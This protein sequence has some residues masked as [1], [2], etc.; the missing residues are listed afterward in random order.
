MSD[1]LVI[2]VL[3]P[4]V[5]A[6]FGVTV[7]AI[8]GRLF[9]LIAQMTTGLTLVA[10]LVLFVALDRAQSGV[11]FASQHPW[12]GENLQFTLGLDGVSAVGFVLAALVGFAGTLLGRDVQ[13][14]QKQFHLLYLVLVAGALGAFAVRNLFFFY[15]FME[16]EVLVSYVLI[17]GWGRAGQPEDSVQRERAAMQLSLFASAGALLALLGIIALFSF[18]PG[19]LNLDQQAAVLQQ[20]P[21][22]ATAANWIV[23]L[24]VLGFGVLLSAWPLHIW[25][26]AAYAAA[27]TSVA[28]FSAGVLKQ[29][30]AYGLLRLVLPLLPAESA[31]L[32]SRAL[33]AVAVM[34]ILYLG[35]ITLWQTDGK[36]LIAW[37]SVSHAGYLLLGLAA[38]TGVGAQG[39][40]LMIF[41]SGV[42]AALLFGLWG[43]L[44]AQTGKRELADY[45]GLAR[46]S[47][48]L[49]VAFTMA[50]LAAIGLPGFA[51]FVSE[52][53]VLF[54][55]WLQGE[56]WMR[57]AVAAGV[58]GLVLTAT[59]F[60][61]A[62]RTVC[63]GPVAPTTEKLFGPNDAEKF[64]VALL[65]AFLLAA[66]VWP[67]LATDLTKQSFPSLGK[68]SVAAFQASEK[69]SSVGG[70]SSSRESNL[71]A[72]TTRELELP[73]TKSMAADA[74]DEQLR[75]T[76]R[77]DV[78]SPSLRRLESRRSQLEQPEN[79]AGEKH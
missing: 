60:L 21:L 27:P 15:F 30:A 8:S 65:L 18:A 74:Q 3:L 2:T 67:R 77:G 11:Q 31:P 79:K 25:A 47:P 16:F 68:T 53:L 1:L 17:A 66:G 78:S 48:F 61:R 69:S 54:G 72:P 20:T 56:L 39:V 38:L 55:A 29:L 57:L 10:S 22:P 49:G 4:L 43:V 41:A 76:G 6:L 32:W 70:S 44:E 37:A 35:W 34:N 42:S 58:W 46:R 33:A 9:R 7:P 71:A 52:I 45:G 19:A 14:R 75:L 26:P 12:L 36:K 40:A 5:M 59:Y 50:V 73:P 23:L 51:N 63:F 13:T 64:A 62:V 24:L 28:M